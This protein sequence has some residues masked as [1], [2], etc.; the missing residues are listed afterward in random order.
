MAF[1]GKEAVRTV[2]RSDLVRIID[3]GSLEDFMANRIPTYYRD[4]EHIAADLDRGYFLKMVADT[5]RRL[6]TAENF[7]D[8][9][10]GELL[11]A[12]FAQAAMGLRLLYS[13]LRLLTAENA[14]AYKM[15]VVMY[16][17]AAQ[18]VELVFLEVKSSVK[19]A[20]DE[21]ARHDAS[22]Y[23]DL[24]QSLNKY[25]DSDVQYDLTAVRDRLSQLPV[26]DQSQLEAEFKRYGGPKV[27]YAGICSIDVETHSDEEASLLATR[28]NQKDIDVDFDRPR[29]APPAP[30]RR[31]DPAHGCRG[32]R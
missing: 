20:A 17:L 28:K 30:A 12:E 8:S 16:D 5:L 14:N 32:R 1:H 3:A 27:R 15:D 4:P 25:V 2:R 26:D 24:F 11:A 7:R 6:P 29:R 31:Q 18:P 21:P 10:F 19:V 22:I 9:H 23:A 13:K